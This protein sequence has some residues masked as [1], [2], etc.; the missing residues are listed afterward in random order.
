MVLNANHLSNWIEL[1]Y[2]EYSSIKSIHYGNGNGEEGGM[3][4]GFHR[5]CS[6][7]DS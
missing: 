7:F 1:N 3:G 2:T 4:D 5:C 6:F